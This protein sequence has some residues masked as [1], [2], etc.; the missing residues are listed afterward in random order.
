MSN[1]PEDLATP[2][3][4]AG[5]PAKRTPADPAVAAWSV[6]S[7]TEVN[8]EERKIPWI[9]G[10]VQSYGQWGGIYE[11]EFVELVL[12]RA[13]PAGEAG[14]V[15]RVVLQVVL[16]DIFEVNKYRKGD[17]VF[18]QGQPKAGRARMFAVKLYGPPERVRELSAILTVADAEERAA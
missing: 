11:S 16:K 17:L 4:L 12:D 15:R 10:E 9:T 5:V 1:N 6:V 8:I 7:L 14:E 3:A 2:P 13:Q 18:V